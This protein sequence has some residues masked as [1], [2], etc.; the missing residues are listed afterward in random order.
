VSNLHLGWHELH[1]DVSLNFQLNRWAAYGGQRWLADVRP[2]LPKLQG[3]DGWR[4]TFG[5]LGERAEADGR[6]LDAA[7]HF[8]SAEFFIMPSDSR[9]QP[10]QQRLLALFREAVGVSLN[11][12][13]EVPFDG[14]RLPAWALARGEGT[15]NARRL[16]RL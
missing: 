14:L 10:L 7:L 6:V 2:I 5:A 8:R 11:A 12:R 16:R 9:K 1:S 15:G 3:Y 4:D 13:R